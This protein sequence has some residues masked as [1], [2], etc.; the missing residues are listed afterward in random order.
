MASGDLS[1]YVVGSEHHTYVRQAKRRQFE[2]IIIIN[3]ETYG[4]HYSGNGIGTSAMPMQQSQQ[5][6]TYARKPRTND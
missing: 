2:I 4:L 6:S 3:G 1:S 5:V